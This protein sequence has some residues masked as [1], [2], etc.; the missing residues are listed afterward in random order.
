MHRVFWRP[1]ICPHLSNELA[2][3][4]KKRRGAGS[5]LP[6]FFKGQRRLIF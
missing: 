6:L 3:V 4:L 5:S 1:L 2:I